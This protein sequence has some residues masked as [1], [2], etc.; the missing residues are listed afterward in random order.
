[1]L[2]NGTVIPGLI[3]ATMT[4]TNNY[5]ADE[6]ECEFS[7][8]DDPKFGPSFFDVEELDIDIQLSIVTGS[9][10]DAFRSILLGKTDRINVKWFQ[11]TV[12]LSGRDKTSLFLDTKI[13]ETYQNL[14]SSEVVSQ[15]ANGHPGITSDIDPTTT[16]V[17]SYYAHNQSQNATGEF[18]KSTTEWQLITYLAQQE[19]YDVWVKGNTIHFKQQILQD[20]TPWTINLHKPAQRKNQTYHY[21]NTVKDV[22]LERNLSIAKDVKVI[23]QSW[24]SN[25]GKLMTATYGS[26]AGKNSQTYTRQAPP[27]MT[28][29]QLNRRA[30]SLALEISKNERVINWR[31]PGVSDILTPRNMV[32]VINSGTSFDQNYYIQKI[33]R[34]FSIDGGLEMFISAKNHSVDTSAGESAVSG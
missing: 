18:T 23:L 14:T 32:Q 29:D 2:T 12:I 3:H 1:V 26:S 13:N 33:T 9:N 8:W 24:N 10:K 6:F 34:T 19:G 28:Q 25:D 4:S 20:P 15:L 5:K 31:E 30:N 22:D 17:G 16:K 21:G 11:G 7:L 27:N